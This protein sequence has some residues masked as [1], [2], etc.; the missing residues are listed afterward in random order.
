MCLNQ[1]EEATAS[2]PLW[3]GNQQKTYDFVVFADAFEH[4]LNEWQL[5]LNQ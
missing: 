4:F 1:D 3:T 2:E 5:A